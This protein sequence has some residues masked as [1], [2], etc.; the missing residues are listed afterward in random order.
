MLYT[1]VI[2]LFSGNQHHGG[3]K[4]HFAGKPSHMLQ[5]RLQAWTGPETNLVGGFC[6]I[7]WAWHANHLS[8]LNGMYTWSL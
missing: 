2:Y 4:P 3:R 6:T 7:A 8:Y 5:E 1:E